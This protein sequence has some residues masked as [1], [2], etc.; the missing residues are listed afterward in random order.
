MPCNSPNRVFY[1][2]INP[3]TGKKLIF[4]TS[5]FV[6]YIW[7]R[8][9]ESPW[10]TARLQESQTQLHGTKNEAVYRNALNKLVAPPG[11]Q[12]IIDSDLVPCGQCIG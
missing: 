10:Q 6:D 9:P 11:G 2:G 8:D 12:L 5:R 1:T 3:E 4:Y 7:R